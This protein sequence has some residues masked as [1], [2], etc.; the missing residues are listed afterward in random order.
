MSK[1][2][3]PVT[4]QRQQ[5]EETC[6]STLCHAMQLWIMDIVLPQAHCN[7]CCLFVIAMMHK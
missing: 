4:M 3:V 2:T 6:D 7:L 5:A 1:L